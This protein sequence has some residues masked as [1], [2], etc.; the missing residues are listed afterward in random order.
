MATPVSLAICLWL[1]I[2][3]FTMPA[4]TPL[5]PAPSDQCSVNNV[6]TLVIN[7]T[8]LVPP[9]LE[10][11]TPWITVTEEAFTEASSS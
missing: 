3:S 2:G 9:V 1:A 5:P 11:S 7:V 8:T 4:R 6:T 10:T